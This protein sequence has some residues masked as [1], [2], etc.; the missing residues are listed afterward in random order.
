LSLNVTTEDKFFDKAG[1]E[2]E[3]QKGECLNRILRNHRPES[4]AIVL[5]RSQDCIRQIS[6]YRYRYQSGKSDAAIT[7]DRL[8]AT[9]FHPHQFL[10]RD[11]SAASDADKR[12]GETHPQESSENETELQ[13]GPSMLC[14]L[15]IDLRDRECSRPSQHK[16]ESKQDSKKNRK[17]GGAGYAMSQS[18][19]YVDFH[20]THS[21]ATRIVTAAGA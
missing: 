12:N 9:P 3:Q 6:D 16:R 4:G 5:E 15:R 1:A 10:P 8:P 21:S 7:N 18:P 20:H 11:P 2:G 13:E 19:I 17:V 14:A